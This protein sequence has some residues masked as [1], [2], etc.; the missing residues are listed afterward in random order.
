MR[1][2]AIAPVV[3][4]HFNKEWLPSGYLGVDIFFVISGLVITSSLLHK[5][6]LSFRDNLLAFYSRRVKRLMPA[7]WAV[8]VIGAILISLFNRAPGFSLQTG[9]ASLFGISNLYLLYQATDYFAPATEL[10]IFTHTWS[11]G[12]EEQFYLLFPLLLWLAGPWRSGAGLTT[13]SKSIL[14]ATI[15]TLSIVSLVLFTSLY[16]SHQALT[17]FLMPTRFWEMGLGCLL[18]FQSLRTPADLSR[19]RRRINHLLSWSSLVII[20]IIFKAFPEQQGLA[21]TVAVVL[22]TCVLLFTLH[23]SCDLADCQRGSLYK[24]LCHPRLIAV[25]LIS[26]SLYLW[27]WPILCIS[28]WTIGTPLWSLPILLAIMAG[29]SWLS[30]T[31]LEQ[32]LR[33][34]NWNSSRMKTIGLGLLA[35]LVSSFFL[36]L[37]GGPF[38]SKLFTGRGGQTLDKSRF[39]SE[40]LKDQSKLTKGVDALLK[41]CN[42]TPFL[43]G[44]NSYKTGRKIDGALA[45]DC[46]TNIGIKPTINK[47]ANQR[48][49]LIGDSFAEKLAPFAALAA[50]ENG[51]EFNLFYGYGCAYLLRSGLISNPSFRHC[52][53]FQEEALESALLSSLKK[54]DVI[55][56]R[57]HLGSK[58]YLRYP[59][60]SQQPLPEAYDR[61]IEDLK[62]KI[63]A[64][65]AHLI[66]IGGNPNLATQ[67]LAALQ[68]DWFN[69]WNR[70]SIINPKNSQETKFFHSLD[71]HLSQR[72]SSGHGSTYFS[73]KPLICEDQDACLLS[74]KDKFLYEDDHHLSPYGHEL[75]FDELK[76]RLR[77]LRKPTPSAG[78][79]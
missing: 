33:Q 58:S 28:R 2:V 7:L 45:K 42:A 49:I 75:F 56:L 13:K 69:A 59:S 47:T 44:K 55:I 14:F 76:A 10:N 62:K 71:G 35:S 37:L 4:N 19:K 22:L 9:I 20:L 52:R 6:S 21:A 23:T 1:A 31:A 41:Q 17:Y 65:Q 15:L 73:L 64:K 40:L 38:K 74:R 67:D 79:T 57:L 29:L 18:A 78:M 72:F 39:S 53:Y 50:L 30:Y 48:V 11:L 46:F 26:Y 51:Y 43:L 27:H 3:I 70:S 16:T 8:V 5:P 34:A 61:A 68:P 54:D 36:L 77:Q 63:T 32:P 12:V 24:V 66:L 60:G 25:G